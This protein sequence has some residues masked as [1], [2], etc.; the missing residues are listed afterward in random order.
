MTKDGTAMAGGQDV[1]GSGAVVVERVVTPR[2]EL[3]LRRAQ[4]THHPTGARSLAPSPWPDHP[5]SLQSATF[6]TA[7]LGAPGEAEQARQL[8]HDTLE[9]CRRVLGPDHMT[10][11][12]SAASLTFA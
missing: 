9:R 4:S 10:T 2:G 12:A 6:L 7:E 1:L 3:V 5:D 11:V 8:G